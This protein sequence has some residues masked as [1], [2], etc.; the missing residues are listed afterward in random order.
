MKK[1]YHRIEVPLHFS[2]LGTAIDCITSYESRKLHN[3]LCVL[4]MRFLHL[5]TEL[6]YQGLFPVRLSHNVKDPLGHAAPEEPRRESPNS[7]IW[8]FWREIQ[9]SNLSMRAYIHVC[10][11]V[12]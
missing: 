6:P 3:A 12:Y 4:T 10:R 1:S 2:G 9:D 7:R 5:T 8:T 11:H